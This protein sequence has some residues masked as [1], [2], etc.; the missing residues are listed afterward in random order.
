[1]SPYTES[2]VNVFE[3]K[4]GYPFRCDCFQ[5]RDN[6]YPLTKA[7]VYYDHDRVKTP[8]GRKVS[9]EINREESERD[10]G[11]GRDWDEQWGYQCLTT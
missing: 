11:G 8:G 7:M 9:D 1:M 6:N 5:A 4:F 10:S 3:E 2:L